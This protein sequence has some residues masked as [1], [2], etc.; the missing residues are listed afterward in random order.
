M[1]DDVEPNKL[2]SA[3]VSQMEVTLTESESSTS[4]AVDGKEQAPPASQTPHSSPM[5][6][7]TDDAPSSGQSNVTS[8][9]VID[10]TRIS[11]T[12]TE[13]SATDKWSSD[14]RLSQHNGQV[15]QSAAK[16]SPP[17]SEEDEG[18]YTMSDTEYPPAVPSSEVIPITDE[19]G[20]KEL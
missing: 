10:T 17:D 12:E 16:A 7:S 19:S 9:E 4:S 2:T 3:T 18:R 11:Q 20:S 14:D 1:T 15:D 8:S 5:D 13:T 6:V